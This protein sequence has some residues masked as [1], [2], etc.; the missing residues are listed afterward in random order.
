MNPTPVQDLRHALREAGAQSVRGEQLQV[1]DW[2]LAGGSV[3]CIQKITPRVIQ[4]GPDTYLP[5]H[6]DEEYLQI[7]V[8]FL[9]PQATGRTRRP[10]DQTGSPFDLPAPAAPTTPIAGRALLPQSRGRTPS[11]AARRDPRARPLRPT[12]TPSA[13]AD[14][15]LPFPAAAPAALGRGF[16]VWEPR[17]RSQT[18]KPLPQNRRS[19]RRGTAP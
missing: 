6:D 4:T 3:A 11:P 19:P 9:P 16:G 13:S 8:G 2:I 7:P 1:G 12:W 10:A 5:F 14:W 18:P 17:E 15:P